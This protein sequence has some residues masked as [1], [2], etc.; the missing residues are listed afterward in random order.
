MSII[1]SWHD[2]RISSAPIFKKTRSLSINHL[3]LELCFWKPQF[4][5]HELK[6]MKKFDEDLTKPTV[7]VLRRGRVISYS[8]YK[9]VISCKMNLEL[10]PIDIQACNMSF[11]SYAIT[12]TKLQ[13]ATRMV[14]TYRSI[15]TNDLT[16]DLLDMRQIADNDTSRRM[17]SRLTIQFIFKRRLDL[18]LMTTYFPSLLATIVSFTSFWIHPDAVP[19]RVTL[20]VTCLLALMT[21]MVSVRNAI[22][23][24]NYV[25]SIDIW[26]LA[27]IT[28]VALS[29]FEFALAYTLTRNQK[30]NYLRVTLQTSKQLKLKLKLMSLTTDQLSRISFPVLFFSFVVSY[31]LVLVSLTNERQ[32]MFLH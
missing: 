18:Y 5:A 16:Y 8:D 3:T 13:F 10:F 28:F 26:F 11:I 27:C 24:T 15:K 25:T 17:M 30:I 20:G 32:N 7:A 22:N 4:N 9:F 31:F 29:L 14:N 23:N 21:Q 2:E 6:S 12:K 19:G 1:L